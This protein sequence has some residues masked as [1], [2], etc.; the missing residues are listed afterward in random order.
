MKL[1]AVTVPVLRIWQ[2]AFSTPTYHRFRGL[3]L[4][5]MLTTGRRTITNIGRTVRP[6]AQSPVASSHRVLSPRRWSAWALARRLLTCLLTSRVPTGPGWLVGDETVAERPGPHVFGKGRHRDG[7]RSPPSD[8]A[9]RWEHT[10]VV[11]S[12]RVKFPCAIR[13]WALPVLVVWCH[14]PAWDQAHGTRHQTPAHLARLR[15]AR[16]GRWCPARPFIL[17]GDTGD[18]T[19]ETARCCHR[20]GRQLT[21]VSKVYGDAA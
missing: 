2:P 8:T 10:W 4:G 19:S 21:L 16:V 17:V 12:V 3:W 13:P 14:D 6:Y 7:V 9:S 18:G 11:V 5:A 20:H 1:P 15:L